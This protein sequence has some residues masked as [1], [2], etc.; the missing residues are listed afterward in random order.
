M[1]YL[2]I[3]GSPRR[4]NTW[5]IVEEVKKNLDKQ[6]QNTYDQIELKD[7]EL[8]MCTACYNCFTNGENTCPH[9]N[10][11]QPITEKMMQYDGLIITSPVYVLNVT[12][13]IKNLFDHLAYI[14]HRPQFFKK[15][16]LIIVTT[17]G[18]GHK[19][20]ANYMDESLQNMGYNQRYKITLNHNQMNPLQEKTIK[21]I[22]KTANKFYQA[23]KNKTLKSPNLKALLMY[24]V[25]RAMANN[26]TTQPDY[27]YWTQNNMI[28]YEYH[29]DIPCNSLKKIPFKIFYKIIAKILK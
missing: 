3:N 13:H 9:A 7:L 15:H 20:V 8:P 12:A 19:K 4:K 5:Q 26:K 2:V 16:A 14:Y 29:P 10:I 18:T 27:Q 1:K 28:Q 22:T 24:N 25:W 21:E 17:A 11:I 23:T 6:E